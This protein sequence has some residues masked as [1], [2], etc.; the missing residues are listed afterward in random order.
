METEQMTLTDFLLAR[1]SEDE[2][3][4]RGAYRDSVDND[5]VCHERWTDA[6]TAVMWGDLAAITGLEADYLANHIARH[7]PARVLAEC[8]AKRRIVALHAN[9]GEA[10]GLSYC[11]TCEDRYV[12]DA[13][14]W[15]CPSIRPLALPYSDHEDFKEEWRA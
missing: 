15:P 13:A 11:A 4:A 10:D 2:E 1:F 14:D 6:T 5:G 7:D 8:E 3:I 12:H 9:E